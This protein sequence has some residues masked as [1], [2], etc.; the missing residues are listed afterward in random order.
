MFVKI[1]VSQEAL[2]SE[3]SWKYSAFLWFLLICEQHQTKHVNK[4]GNI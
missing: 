1:F 3:N 4:S 2:S